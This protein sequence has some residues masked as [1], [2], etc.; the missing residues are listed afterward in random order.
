V[1]L[2]LKIVLGIAAFALSFPGARAA[3]FS[4]QQRKAAEDLY[5][6]KC[7]K[8]HKFY[9]PAEY[10][11]KDWDMWMR[12]MSRKSKLKPAQD[13]LLARYLNEY[14]ERHKTAGVR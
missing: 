5:N 11:Q 13:E 14:R 8:C 10:S 12:K 7:A 9:D 4:P 3:D 6:I 1:R 2:F